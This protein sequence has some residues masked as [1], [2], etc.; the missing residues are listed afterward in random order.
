MMNFRLVIYVICDSFG[1]PDPCCM[2]WKEKE[3]DGIR[4][5]WLVL[6][7]CAV[8]CHSQ[9]ACYLDGPLSPRLDT[10]MLQIYFGMLFYHFKWGYERFVTRLLRAGQ[11]R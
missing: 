7:L 5:C 9:L 8:R 2:T 6:A 11:A 3:G 10:C 1:K 4:G